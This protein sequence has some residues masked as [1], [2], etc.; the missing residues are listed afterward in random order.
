MYNFDSYV[1]K[2]HEYRKQ[3]NSRKGEMTAREW[4][5]RNWG[6]ADCPSSSFDNI[7]NAYHDYRNSQQWN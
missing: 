1:K 7:F 2:E 6:S 5:N 3:I 4:T